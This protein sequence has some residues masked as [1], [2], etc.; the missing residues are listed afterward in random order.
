MERKKYR[1]TEKMRKRIIIRNTSKHIQRL[2]P[3][4]LPKSSTVS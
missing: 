1:G 3:V 4:P 2:P